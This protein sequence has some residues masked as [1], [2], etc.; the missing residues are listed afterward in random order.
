M[1]SEHTVTIIAFV[2][3]V[4]TKALDI[5]VVFDTAAVFIITLVG[6]LASLSVKWHKST[7]EM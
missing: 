6:V 1:T 3:I 4:A 2:H 7:F 5:S